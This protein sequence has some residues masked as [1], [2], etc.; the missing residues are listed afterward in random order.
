[1]KLPVKTRILQYAIDKNGDFTTNDVLELL[2]Q[3]YPGEGMINRKQ[4]QEYIDS[5]VGVGFFK[6]TEI[7]FDEK[8]NLQLRYVVTDYGK[9]RKKYIH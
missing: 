6:A 5:L 2:K 3:E 9:S 1:M 4:I 7:A 8:H